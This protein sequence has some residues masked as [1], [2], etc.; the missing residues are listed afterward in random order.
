MSNHS[1]LSRYALPVAGASVLW[2]ALL[3]V[4]A[5][6]ADIWDAIAPMIVPMPFAGFIGAAC[7]LRCQG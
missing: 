5:S 2:A 6:R 3:A 1:G 4:A 7:L